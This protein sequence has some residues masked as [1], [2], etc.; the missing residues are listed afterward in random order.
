[1]FREVTVTKK[2]TDTPF[3]NLCNEEGTSGGRYDL[4]RFMSFTMLL[5]IVLKD[6]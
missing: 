2:E 6:K 4:G 1:M 3:F 5:F